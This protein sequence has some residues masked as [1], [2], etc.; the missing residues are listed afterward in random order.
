[1]AAALISIAAS[2][3]SVF[4]CNA[5]P[6]YCSD[7]PRIPAKLKAKKLRLAAEY[8]Q[9]LVDLLDRGV[10]CVARINSSPDGF[11]MV[12]V[13]QGGGIDVLPWDS[14]NEA[15]TRSELAAGAVTRFWIVNARRAFSCDGEALY[16]QRNV[17][18]SNDDVNM[19][20]ALKGG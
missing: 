14:D 3:T 17:Y 15:A 20:L 13:K 4:A 19:S 1:M 10:Q 8:P 5:G 9:R 6:D 11:S 7:D 2:G 16:N 12:I 18:N